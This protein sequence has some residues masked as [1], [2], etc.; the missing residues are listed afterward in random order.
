MAHE[1]VVVITGAS[2]GIGRDT[3]RRFARRHARLV[4]VSRREEA[5]EQVVDECVHAG[6]PDAVA[7][8][9]D[10]SDETALQNV[11]DT[12][13]ARFG[14]IDV[15]V[16][17]AGVDAY[18]PLDR[19]EPDDLRRLFETNTIGTA[20]GTRAALRVMKSTGRGTIVNVSS[21]LAEVP[22]PYAAAYSASKASVRALSAAVRAELRLEKHPRIH[23]STV[24]PATIDTPLFRHA[25]NR[26]GRRLRA[27]PPVYPV[28][29][30][31]KAILRAARRHPAELTAG[32]AAAMF[33]PMHRA[34][35][36]TTEAE[37]ALLTAGTQFRPGRAPDT[38]GNLSQPF[39][40]EDAS[41]GG[42]WGGGIRHRARRLMLVGAFA[43]PLW[44]L[45][46]RAKTGAKR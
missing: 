5:L 42:G 34:L 12:A 3:A 6:A 44:L 40:D 8:P 36:R 11:V 15:W 14:R 9:A 35:P 17:D 16:N 45:V 41:T 43:L 7:V 27:L 19:M 2:S 31:S 4:L 25:A 21:V 24:L 46:R 33:V 26:S 29:T 37:L 20:L 28:S 30:A 32:S 38:G 10:I 23:V 39:G 13:L 22:Q 18:G 1:Q